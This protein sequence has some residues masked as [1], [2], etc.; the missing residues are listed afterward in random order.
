MK[1]IRVSEVGHQAAAEAAARALSYGSIVLLPTDTLYGLAVDALN[2]EAIERLRVVKGRESNKPISI[3]V[4]SVEDVSVFAT[5]HA[6]AQEFAERHLPGALTLVVE[7]KTN[8]PDSLVLSGAIGIRVPNDA[9]TKELSRVHK[10]PYTATSANLSGQKTLANPMDIIVSLGEAAEMVSLV[11]DDGPREGMLPSTV[12]LY[13]GEVP[14]VLRDG[15][16]SRE[17]L[18]IE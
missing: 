9:F 17:Q 11:I 6:H 4:P 14:L 18:G 12:V 15:A 16:L 8:V 2:K 3:I 1:V 10:Q 13:T 7:A 5:M